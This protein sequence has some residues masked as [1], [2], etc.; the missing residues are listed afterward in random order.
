[1]SKIEFKY[2]KGAV[3]RA[4]AILLTPRN[5]EHPEAKKVLD[6]W[7]A[8]HV[9][10]LNSFQTSLRKKLAKI[11]DQALVSQPGFQSEVQFLQPELKG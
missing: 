10:P 7:R 1:M 8:C 9:A 4:G 11:D 5:D 6:N 2:S 3:N